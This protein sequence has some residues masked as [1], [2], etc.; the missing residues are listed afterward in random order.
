[1]D[2]QKN[3]LVKFDAPELSVIEKSKAEQIKATFEPMAKMLSEFEEKFNE[4]I[5][6]SE[7]EVTKEITIKAKRLRID[8]GK[9]RIETDKIRKDQKDEYLRAGKAIDG[10]ANILKWAVTDK[11]N[12]LKEIEDYFEI[13]EKK[14]LELLQIERVEKLQKYVEDAH[15]RDLSSMDTDV[16]DIYLAGKKKEF[17]DKIE[18][19]KKA[20]KERIENEKLDKLENSRKI[21]IAPYNQFMKESYD[22][23]SMNESDYNDLL[24]FLNQCKIKHDEEQEKIRLENEKLKE[25][26]EKQAKQ[27]EEER[28]EA[29]KKQKAIEEQAK[30]ERKEAI[31]KQ[32]AIEEQAKKEREEIEHKNKIEDEKQAELLRKQKEEAEKL[33]AELQAKKDAELKAEQEKQ[34]S[35][36]AEMSKGD[37]EKFKSL[38]SDISYLKNKYTFKSKK[39]QTIQNSINDLLEKTVTY[40]NT[41]L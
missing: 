32:K 36:E 18:A 2:E 12:K 26:A 31:K 19:K 13:Q 28:K 16:F 22:L 35:I 34:A 4:I 8:I 25:E 5:K 41:K 17:E 20:E 23:R 24:S 9:V 30:K 27:L 10:V 11:E 3:E 7:K 29:I 37:N 38:I 15:E 39:Y 1:M 14:R 21:E 33:Q 6:N 40:A